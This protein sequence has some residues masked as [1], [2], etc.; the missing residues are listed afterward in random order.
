MSQDNLTFTGGS[1]VRIERTGPRRY[2][3]NLE[4][5]GSDQK[6]IVFADRPSREA[7]AF[8]TTGY[9]N[10]LK[11]EDNAKGRNI[12][13]RYLDS[14]SKKHTDLAFTYQ[15]IVK[16]KESNE[17][18]FLVEETDSQKDF[19]QLGHTTA[20]S[21]A[22]QGGEAQI[23]TGPQNTNKSKFK[24]EWLALV[25]GTNLEL[26]QN[27]DLSYNITIQGTSLETLLFGTG[28]EA[29]L[30]DIKTW[31][32]HDEWGKFFSNSEPNALLTYYDKSTDKSNQIVFKMERPIYNSKKGTLEFTGKTS[33]EH[34]EVNGFTEK[35]QIDVL[36]GLPYGTNTIIDGSSP[37]LFIDDITSSGVGR[38]YPGEKYPVSYTQAVKVHNHTN[39]ELKV[40]GS[41]KGTIQ[42]L[43]DPLEYDIAKG[44]SS[45]WL[46]SEPD[47]M[48]GG[49]VFEVAAN[50]YR[51]TG[52]AWER[53]EPFWVGTYDGWTGFYQWISTELGDD[54][55]WG[56]VHNLYR[57]P[58]SKPT[59]F[60]GSQT[61]YDDK[62]NKSRVPIVYNWE[63]VIDPLNREY[64]PN[65]GEVMKTDIYISGG[66]PAG[67]LID[68]NTIV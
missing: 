39:H 30:R 8:T 65:V 47:S 63:V 2:Q 20:S 35:N 9:Y 59:V 41:I 43:D 51:N 4:Q 60:K 52:L 13:L 23:F 12:V 22:A 38:H 10:Y 6:S 25:E 17:L 46:V 16:N 15:S 11:D 53:I 31:M 27:K 67:L 26:K 3:I 44:N 18:V 36:T 24:S 50:V 37:S 68:S 28:D 34:K 61:M 29:G 40:L 64:M 58:G 21:F 7:Q 19:N 48:F 62:P 45:S 54:K 66:E 32:L 57:K 5:I 56:P 55:L 33:E 14:K 1:S 49:K 42:S